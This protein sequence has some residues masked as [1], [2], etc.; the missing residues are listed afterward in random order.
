MSCLRAAREPNQTFIFKLMQKSQPQAT[1]G[2]FGVHDVLFVLFKHKWLILS[3]SALGLGSAAAVFYTQDP[4]YQSEAKLLVRYVRETGTL[5]TYEDIK[6]PGGGIR[7]KGDPVINTEIEILKSKDLAMEVAEALEA[8]KSPTSDAIPGNAALSDAAAAILGGLEVTPG[9]SSTVLYVTYENK[10]PNLPQ[11]TLD[12]IVELY[13]KKHL[14]IHRSAAAF[15]TVAKQTEEV[16]AQLKQTEIK[17]NQLRTQTGIVSL[18][19]ATEALSSQRSKTLADLMTAKAEMA[20][21]AASIDALEKST[22]GGQRDMDTQHSNAGPAGKKTAASA[23]PP[24]VVTQYKSLVELLSFLRKRDI[25]LRI[26]FKSGNRLLVLNQQQIDD[27]ESKRRALVEHYPD[28]ANEAAAISNDPQNPQSNLIAEKA[29]LAAIRAKIEVFEEHLKEIGEQ[30]SREY[31]IGA[32]IEA[33]ERQ[34]QMEEAEFRSLEANLKSA[35]INQTLDPA[36]MPNITLVQKPSKPVKS[37][38]ETTQKIIFGLAGGGMAIGLGLAFMME[39]LLDRRVKR[40]I[41]IQ[42]RLQLPLLLTIPYIR[43]KDRGGPLLTHDQ[44]MQHIGNRGNLAIPYADSEEVVFETPSKRT[45]HFILPYSE[46]IRDRIIFNFE[47]NNV[48]H[49]PK[50]VAVTGLSE[51]AGSSTIA[52]GLAKSFSEI[53]GTKVL[54]VDLSSYHP[55][56]NPLFGEIPR[57][58]LNGA[59]HLARNTTF[60]ENPQNLY[61][62]SATARR[63]DSGLTTFSP[64]QLYELLPHLQASEYDYIVFDMPP[65]DQ[66]SRTLTMAGLMDKVLLVLDAENTS[67]DGLMWGYS[68]LVK[69]KADVSCIFNKTRTLVPG[70]LIGEN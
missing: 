32:E 39:L 16:G 67:R 61:Y 31:A 5:D 69:G 47:V 28:L 62:A 44:G 42:T 21:H 34:R 54:L 36:R 8:E 50:L 55:E 63:D 51:G 29:R 43:R 3:L 48:T 4:I 66:T 57:H 20:E 35:R 7:G 1:K 59:L 13:F 17:V 2:G 56:E 9:Q 22:G 12:K 26:K 10:N 38:D 6:S 11:T 45:G 53:P 52:A 70:W 41:E 65:I 64:V 24:H 19:A 60:R 15:D 25:E 37:F 27:Y 68:E 14:E 18:A 33:L 58:S 30:F 40:P 49:K 46:T 23:S